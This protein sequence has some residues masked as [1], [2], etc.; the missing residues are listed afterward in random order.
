MCDSPVHYLLSS[1]LPSFPPPPSSFLSL[2]LSP[3]LILPINS[4]LYSRRD[5]NGGSGLSGEIRGVSFCLQNPF[6]GVSSPQEKE[7][8]NLLM[9]SLPLLFMIME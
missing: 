2:S 4:Y 5:D 8:G 6:I 9:S 1:F 3:S 7:L